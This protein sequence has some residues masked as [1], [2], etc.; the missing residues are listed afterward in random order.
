MDLELGLELAD[1]PLGCREL[2]ALDGC[3]ARDQA[4]VD[5]LLAPPGVDRLVA[6]PQVT[7][8]VD[9]PSPCD[10][11]IEHPAA[12]LRWVSPSSHGASC[13]GRQP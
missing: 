6:D 10:E 2:F 4:P 8:Q 12:E 1:A 13:S 11:Q 7:G 5:S 9:D 3:Q